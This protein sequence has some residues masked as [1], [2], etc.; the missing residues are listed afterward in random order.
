MGIVKR[1]TREARKVEN[2]DLEKMNKKL[3]EHFLLKV[4]HVKTMR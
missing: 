1:E 3:R 2:S 4:L